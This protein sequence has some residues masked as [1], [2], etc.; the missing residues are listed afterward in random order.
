MVLAGAVVADA[1]VVGAVVASTVA[2]GSVVPGLELAVNDA[3]S[4]GVG[5]GVW[6]ADVLSPSPPH[7]ES[8]ATATSTADTRA[9][10]DVCAR[11]TPFA[12][13]I[14]PRMTPSE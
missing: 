6:F 7:A 8:N 13:A 11:W 4:T 14:A 1:V 12:G 5:A 3:V 10:I 9:D 2:V